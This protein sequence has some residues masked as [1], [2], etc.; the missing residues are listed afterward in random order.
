MKFP[1]LRDRQRGARR[2]GPLLEHGFRGELKKTETIPWF[3]FFNL[4][5]NHR[6]S[7]LTECC[8]F[9]PTHEGKTIFPSEEAFYDW[10]SAVN[11]RKKHREG[12]LIAI[13]LILILPILFAAAVCYIFE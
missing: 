6:E 13:F 3:T 2:G 1:W 8:L 7:I 12:Q 10:I 11:Q 9:D 5:R 4:E